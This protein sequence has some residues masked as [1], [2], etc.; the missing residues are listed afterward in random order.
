MKKPNDHSRNPGMSLIQVHDGRQLMLDKMRGKLA[1]TSQFHA[2]ASE[3]RR[4][5]ARVSARKALLGWG[6]KIG[7][8][9]LIA[10]VNIVWLSNHSQGKVDVAPR[11]A[12]NL[13][14]PSTKLTI[15]EQALYWAYALYDFD[16]LKSRFG[17]AKGVVIDSRLALANLQQLLPKVDPRTRFV[18][19]RYQPAPKRG[20][21]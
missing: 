18:I 20:S 1:G 8:L 9:G 7:A 14:P 4:V 13:I 6:W 2:E 17:A 5:S 15:D 16:K 19:D 11:H 3:R 10:A 12:P 21:L